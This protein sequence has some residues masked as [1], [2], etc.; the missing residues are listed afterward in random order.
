MNKRMNN[1][2][3]KKLEKN[4][5]SIRKT[6]TLKT[7]K[8]SFIFSMKYNNNRNLIGTILKSWTWK[9]YPSKLKMLINLYFR[10]LNL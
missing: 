1:N 2:L 3:S 9:R 8:M 7:N 4:T 6:S 10:V 5:L